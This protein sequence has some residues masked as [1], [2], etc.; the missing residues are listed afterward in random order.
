MKKKHSINT[1]SLLILAVLV[2]INIVSFYYYFR[3]DLT[4]DG[5]YSL[6]KA[7][8]DILRSIDE[9]V[10]V[11]AYFT[12]DLPPQLAKTKSDF[13]DLLIEYNSASRG[14]VVYEF[15]NPNA[16][17]EMEARAFQEGIRPVII[18]AREKDQV[19]QQKVYLGAVIQLGDEKEIIP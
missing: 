16:D 9:T 7:S 14:N 6:S 10:T 15:I 17:Q 3:I 2:L 8:K 18:N 13:K 12:E 4:E 5:I 1:K 19:K 11:S